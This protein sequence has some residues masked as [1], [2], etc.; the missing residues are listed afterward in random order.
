MPDKWQHP[1][2]RNEKGKKKKKQGQTEDDWRQE[3]L[4]QC[5]RLVRWKWQRRMKN[6]IVLIG[7]RI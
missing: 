3:F 6:V 5:W 4:S 7:Y 1:C 2:D